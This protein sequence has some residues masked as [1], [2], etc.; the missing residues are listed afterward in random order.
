M[1]CIY[2][3]K[4]IFFHYC[5]FSQSTKQKYKAIFS[6]PLLSFSLHSLSS[7]VEIKLKKGENWSCY[8]QDDCNMHIWFFMM[9][10]NC[11]IRPWNK[12]RLQLPA[13]HMQ[14]LNAEQKLWPLGAQQGDTLY[15]WLCLFCP[16]PPTGCTGQRWECA[17]IMICQGGRWEQQWEYKCTARYDPQGPCFTQSVALSAVVRAPPKTTTP[18][19]NLVPFQNNL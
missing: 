4:N 10:L 9:D 18:L 14:P 16:F 1:G 3:I 5:L 17:C 8:R 19:R 12:G 11:W 13:H 2:D 6:S 15:K 7:P